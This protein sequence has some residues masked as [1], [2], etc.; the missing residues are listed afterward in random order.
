MLKYTICFIRRGQE[1]LLLN[2]L[3]APNMGLWNGVGGKLEAFEL[4]LDGIIREIQEET[5]LHVEQVHEAGIVKWISTEGES[6]M[7]LFYCELSIDAVYATPIEKDEGILAWKSIEWVLDPD[8]EGVVDNMKHFLPHVLTGNF[9][10]EH[11]FTYDTNRIVNYE[12]RALT[13]KKLSS[14]NA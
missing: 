11:T 8:N 13:T 12:C 10:C 6:G 2:R 14:S 1:L 9:E 4:P 7:Y 3:K 5:G